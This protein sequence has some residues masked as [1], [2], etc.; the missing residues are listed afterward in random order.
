MWSR[1]FCVNILKSPEKLPIGIM[2]PGLDR[3]HPPYPEQN[4]EIGK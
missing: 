3:S 4:K 2:N 1:L